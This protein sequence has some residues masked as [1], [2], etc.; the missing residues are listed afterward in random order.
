MIIKELIE[1]IEGEAELDFTFSDDPLNAE[2]EDVRISFAYF[3]GI[4]NILV[5]KEARDALVI[6]PRVCGICNHAH[7]IA[8]VECIEN[9]YRDAGVKFELTSKA[10]NI[11]EFTL[12]CELMQNHIMWFYSTIL[13]YLEKASAEK[14]KDSHLLKASFFSSTI[15][16]AL[17]IFAGQWPHSSYA[18][19]GGVTCDPTYVDVMQAENLLD[20]AIKFY[21]NEVISMPLEKYIE[22]SVYTFSNDM[23]GDFAKA[24]RLIEKNN[25][26]FKGKSHDRFIAFGSSSIFKT[27]KAI[28]TRVNSINNSYVEESTQRDTMAKAVTYRNKLYEVGP[29]SRAMIAKDAKVK[30][31]HKRYKDSVL[32]RVYARVHEVAVLLQQNKKLLQNLKLDE[33]SCVLGKELMVKNFAGTSAVEAARGSLIHKTKVKNGIIEDYEIIVPTQWNLSHGNSEE[34]GVSVKAMLGSKTTQEATFI[35]RTFDICSVCTTQ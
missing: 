25:L 17:A 29:L 16:K 1:K 2:I 35:F 18:I 34:K 8:A 26:S 31:V 27:G 13:P 12:S 21:E 33:R 28:G 3:R 4:E 32:T 30:R 14:S 20:K 10:K 24:M 9:G 23:N 5:G 11:R 22:S 6:T 15:T 7:L 19:P